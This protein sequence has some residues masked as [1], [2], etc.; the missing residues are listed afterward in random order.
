MVN[1][2]PSSISKDTNYGER[3]IF[4]AFEDVTD[5]PDWTVLYSL[6]QYKVVKGRE[7]EGDFVVLIPGKGIVVI[8]AKGAT[9]VD[10]EGDVWVIDGVHSD[11]RNKSPMEQAENTRNNVIALL[12]QNDIDVKSLPV[13]RL[14]WFPKMDPFQFNEIGERGMEMYGWELAFREGL[15]N[16]VAVLENVIDKQ[17]SLGLK[18][19]NLK[20]RPELFDVT[21]M[22]RIND[23]LRVRASAVYSKAGVDEVRRTELSKSTTHL[24]KLW[25][26]IRD[27]NNFYFE[28]AAGTGKSYLLGK[29]AAKFAGDGFKVLITCY[30]K[31]MANEYE[32]L[33]G[34]HPNID[35]IQINDFFLQ[36]AHIKSHKDGDPWYDEELPTKAIN[37]VS[38]NEFLARYDAICIDEF[39]DIASKPKVVDAILRFYNRESEE[40]TKTALAGDDFQQIMRTSDSV[41]GFEVASSYLPDLFRVSLLSNCRQAPGLSH[42][43]F[44]FLG[45]ND[46]DFTHELAKDVEWSFEVARTTD[47][48]E[49]KQLIT[50]VRKLLEKTKPERI[51]I[52]SPY[53]ENKSLLAKFFA[54]EPANEDEIWLRANLR[55]ITTQ[56]EIR[57]R[58]ISKYK[59]LE[60]DV[61]VITDI[62][63]AARDWQAKIGL[64]LN[65][66]LY[67][68]LT[69]ARF[70]VVLLVGDGLF[71]GH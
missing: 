27:N 66:L 5:R 65:E 70:Q 58:S 36:V 24:D 11:A 52:L 57:W 25:M 26:A 53:G 13:A 46:R 21:E 48:Q 19:K 47:G 35:V 43:I 17:I 28:G 22:G 44:K 23:C 6:H 68:G 67:V 9:G 45:W 38:Y 4:S 49:I 39:Q 10:L 42:A 14:V 50:V 61:V 20:Y 34:N 7:A 15:K 16:I 3:V 12:A 56:G 37:A 60:E 32:V 29:A 1:L 54:R 62:N 30:S 63:A 18:V 59:G 31:M 64:N 8:E 33:Y 69:R 2:F 51:R 41:S 71:P 40:G 55:H